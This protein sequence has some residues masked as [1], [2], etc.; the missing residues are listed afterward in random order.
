MGKSFRDLMVWQHSIDLTTEIYRLTATFPREEMI[1]AHLS[2]PT[3]CCFSSEQ[4]CGG[5][6]AARQR[7]ISTV[8][9]HRPR[10]YL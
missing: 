4:H 9:E 1:W 10:I 3:G 8:F 5:I 2:T 6:G 7:R